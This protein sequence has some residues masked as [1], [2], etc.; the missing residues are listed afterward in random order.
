[1]TP[2]PQSAVPSLADWP[3]FLQGIS[4]PPTGPRSLGTRKRE[5]LHDFVRSCLTR[6]ERLIIML[7]YAE[8]LSMPEIAAVLAIDQAKVEEM[9][10]NVVARLRQTLS[11]AE[12]DHARPFAFSGR[13]S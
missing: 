10:G 13:R 6:E 3:L 2:V 12:K 5:S 9:H 8:Q 11:R 4:I 7:H 1:M